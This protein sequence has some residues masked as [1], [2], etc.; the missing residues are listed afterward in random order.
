[1]SCGFAKPRLSQRTLRAR[2]ET[3]SAGHIAARRLESVLSAG[4][5]AISA[6]PASH[7]LRDSIFLPPNTRATG[8][9]P[10][11]GRDCTKRWRP[12]TR[13]L[14]SPAQLS[15]PHSTRPGMPADRPGRPVV[16][17]QQPGAG[18]IDRS[19]SG[20]RGF[21]G[22]GA[23]CCCY[24]GRRGRGAGLTG[25]R[26]AAVAEILRILVPTLLRVVGADV[27]EPAI[28]V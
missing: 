4:H 26:I 16:G 14:V 13:R 3:I 10:A 28:A 5:R 18:W 27:L 23:G 19:R 7:G 11:E 12:E 15:S 24:G 2:R 9:S 22:R 1:M 21:G 8:R 6:V 20:R 25:L 17:G